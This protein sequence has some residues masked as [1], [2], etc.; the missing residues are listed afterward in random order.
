MDREEAYRILVKAP[1]FSLD[2]VGFAGTTPG[3][4]RA[5]RFLLDDPSSPQVFSRLLQGSTAGRLYALVGIYLTDPPRFPQAVQS[6]EG[7]TD[8][9]ETMF[10]GCVVDECS[11]RELARMISSGEI[12]A[13][14]RGE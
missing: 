10:G 7:A 5:F 6:L 1:R 14:L 13:R 8:M 3:T 12:A 11:V 4:V 9:V 2:H